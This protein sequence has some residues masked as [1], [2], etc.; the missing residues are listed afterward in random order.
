S[1]RRRAVCRRCFV[2]GTALLLGPHS[3]R[4]GGQPTGVPPGSGGYVGFDG[5]SAVT[6]RLPATRVPPYRPAGGDGLPA[7]GVAG[8]AMIETTELGEPMAG[9]PPEPVAHARPGLSTICSLVAIL[10]AVPLA[11]IVLTDRL[12]PVLPALRADLR[13]PPNADQLGRML[14]V[15]G[16]AACVA[17][18]LAAWL[19]RVLP[20]WVVL[21]AGLFAVTLGH[22]RGEH[23]ASVGDIDVV[24]VLHGV[25]AACLLVATAALVGAA[26][27]RRGPLVAGAWAAALAGG[28]AAGPWL[29]HHGISSG[30]DWR[31]RLQPYPWL[32]ALAAGLGLAVAAASVADHR[33]RLFPRWI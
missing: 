19:A 8:G 31:D 2:V 22:W 16:A 11:V 6:T 21:L 17:A 9:P 25:G 14:V 20:P 18:P 10:S 28:V 5:V 4:P 30:A 15:A 13:L 23:V 3:S 24:R 27:A 7:G 12:S 26:S 33:P 32:L 29:A 1:R